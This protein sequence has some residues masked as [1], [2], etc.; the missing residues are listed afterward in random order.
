M[1]VYP[2]RYRRGFFYRG[3]IAI[4]SRRMTTKTIS[5]LKHRAAVAV[6]FFICGCTFATWAVR[7]PTIKARFHLNEAQLGGIL[8]LLPLGTLVAL[9]LAGWAVSRA[10]SRIMT[11]AGAICYCLVLVML[12]LSKSTVVLSIALFFFGFCGDALN[13]AMNTQALRVQDEFYQKPLMSSFHGMWSLGA[14]SGA[15]LGGL[16]MKLDLD[17]WQHF[18]WVAGL[19][20]VAAVYFYFFLT[21]KE[22]IKKGEQ[23]FVWPE[24][25]LWLLGA[26]CFC[27]AMSEGAMADWSSLYYQQVLRAAARVST[28]G[29]TAFALMMAVGR[30]IGDRLTMRFGYKGILVL[31]ALLIIV[32]LSLAIGVQQVAAVIAGFGLFGFGV[33][34]IIPVVYTLAC[35]NT[36]MPNSVALASISSVGFT[37]FLVGPPLIGFLAHAVSLRW[38]LCLLIFLAL[39]MLALTQRIKN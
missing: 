13:I 32:G 8:F 30:F 7:I 23:L 26:I 34:T 1:L 9:P 14:M 18:I 21:K 38:A 36:K 24:K 15:A 35:R 5:P 33:A 39:I 20:L 4:L 16:F 25:T 3:G 19:L 27:C 12:G 6:F 2:R 29:Y 11:L 10:G 22:T 31:D 28:T 37:G 17:I